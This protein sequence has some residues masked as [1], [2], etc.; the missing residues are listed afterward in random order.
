M[1]VRRVVLGSVATAMF[2][3]VA[4]AIAAHEH[5]YLQ[6]VLWTA[7]VVAS[8][9]GWGS[10]VNYWI[11]RNRWVDWGL[12]AGWGMG[13]CVV[14]GG[15]LCL[16]HLVNRVTLIGQVVVGLA[17]L[18][19]LSPGRW[20]PSATRC[21]R[22]LV[23]A[24][25]RSG[26]TALVVAAYALLILFVLACFGDHAFQPSDDPA[27]YIALAKKLMESGSIL[28]PFEAHRMPILGGHLYLQALFLAV[29]SPW[30]APVVDGGLCLAII[31]GLVVGHIARPGLKNRHLVP[32]ALAMLLFFGLRSVRVNTGSLFSGVVPILTMYRTVRE[33]L[34]E[35]DSGRPAGTLETWRIACLGALA[36]VAIV[37]RSSIIG[38]V[39][40]FPVLVLALDF[41]RAN[42]RP[43]EWKTLAPFLRQ[44]AIFALAVGFA[45]L[46][47]SIMDEQSSGTFL[48]PLGHNNMTPGI[49]LMSQHNKADELLTRF[50]ANLTYWK[51]IAALLPFLVAGLVPLAGRRKNDLL[52]LTLATVICT[53]T[54]TR[55][56]FDPIDTSRYQ[57]APVVTMGLVVT[58]SAGPSGALA[59]LA[60]M[61]LAAHLGLSMGE[62]HENLKAKIAQAN[63]AYVETKADRAGWEDLTKDYLDVQSHVDPG[64]TMVTAVREGFRFDFRRNTI[65]MLGALGAMGPKPGWPV[66]QGAE[67]LARY[68]HDNGVD[69][70]VWVDFN[71]PGELYNRGHLKANASV[72]D[73]T[74]AKWAALHLGVEDTIEALPKIRRVAFVGHGMTVVDL[75]APPG[76]A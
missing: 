18:L 7:L 43:W 8:F 44:L 33:P 66:H 72:T 20:R 19:A 6:A 31:F 53:A 28:S 38:A 14:V 76:G 15:F 60:G 63:A 50:V 5:P 12:R 48:Y 73:S 45:L 32:L 64:A 55:S 22:R 75:R 52:A 57:F 62:W 61:A 30:Y 9:V 59:T 35:D 65:Y 21:R 34:T 3:A 74:M 69:Y 27:L 26:V 70:I 49:T 11:A 13:L 67:A 42:R 4:T 29:A 47:W 41:A 58:A 39:L 37:M 24:I 2:A 17:A 46:P 25:D 40:S 68:L 51:P 71:E 54:L 56:G 10:A 23:L 16:L 1:L 36:V